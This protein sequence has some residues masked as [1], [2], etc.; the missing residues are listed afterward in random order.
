MERNQ[1]IFKCSDVSIWSQF[2]V[3]FFIVGLVLCSSF[4]ARALAHT[5]VVVL[6]FV[7]EIGDHGEDNLI[8]GDIDNLK[9]DLADILVG[10]GVEVAYPFIPELDQMEYQDLWHQFLEDS[11]FFCKKLY[12]QYK[13]KAHLVY[14]FSLEIKTEET[15]DGLYR[16]KARLMGD[17]YDGYDRIGHDFG[18]NLARNWSFTR[19]HMENAI[20]I[21]EKEAAELVSGKIIGWQKEAMSEGDILNKRR[22]GEEI[23]YH[24]R[25]CLQGATGDE[26]IEAF[27]E[28]LRSTPGIKKIRRIRSRLKLQNP[29]QSIVLWEVELDDNIDAFDLESNIVQTLRDH[30]AI[31]DLLI[32][33]NRASVQSPS[34]VIGELSWIRPGDSSSRELSFVVDWSAAK[35]SRWYRL[36]K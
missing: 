2:I 29:A 5:Q 28:I 34:Q 16:V 33:Y 12:H 25:I 13:N 15:E 32:K 20:A 23:P 21:V 14:V 24:I 7:I 9:C 30:Q 4:S 17:G 3:M 31:D 1:R 35:N 19:D 36:S 11:N 26:F 27:D 8:I 6:P 18:I 10:K 22:T